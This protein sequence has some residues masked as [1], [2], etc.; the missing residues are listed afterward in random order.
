MPASSGTLGITGLSIEQRT[1]LARALGI[2][3]RYVPDD[4][5][6]ADVHG[7][8]VTV[9]LI[10]VT[11]RAIGVLAA[12]LMKPRSKSSKRI[13][14]RIQKPDGEKVEIDVDEIVSREEATPAK[15]IDALA[16]LTGLNAA[17]LT[18]A[19]SAATAT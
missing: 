2:E 4:T 16:R 17:D 15:T 7:D 14:I 1:D 3:D 18:K 8:L 9:F 11:V 19:Y 5:L 6:S 12:W 13:T 10:V